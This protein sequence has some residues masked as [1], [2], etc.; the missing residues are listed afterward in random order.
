MTH[1][2]NPSTPEMKEWK[3]LKAILGSK[4]AWDI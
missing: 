3:K 4:P 2:C 1:A